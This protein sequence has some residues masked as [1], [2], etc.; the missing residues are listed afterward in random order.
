MAVFIKKSFKCFR[1]V[2]HRKA[3]GQTDRQTEI[4]RSKINPSKSNTFSDFRKGKL[5][6]S[7]QFPSSVEEEARPKIEVSSDNAMHKLMISGWVENKNSK[8][9]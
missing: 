6:K 5:Q 7:A 2:T 9:S 1:V 4:C 3:T 8:R